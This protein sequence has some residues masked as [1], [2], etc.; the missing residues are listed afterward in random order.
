MTK[1]ITYRDTHGC[2]EEFKILRE[3]I[4]P[5]KDDKEILLGD[6]LDPEP[7]SNELLYV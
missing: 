6:I 1:T 5:T 3:K 4:Q 7:Y 2:L